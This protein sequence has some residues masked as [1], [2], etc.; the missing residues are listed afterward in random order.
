M[1]ISASFRWIWPRQLRTQ[2]DI[3]KKFQWK[4]NYENYII[5]RPFELSG[6]GKGR[7]GSIYPRYVVWDGIKVSQKFSPEK[8]TRKCK[9][10]APYRSLFELNKI[11]V[12]LYIPSIQFLLVVFESIFS[13]A[14]GAMSIASLSFQ[15]KLTKSWRGLWL[16]FFVAWHF[17]IEYRIL[18]AGLNFLDERHPGPLPATCLC[19]LRDPQ[20]AALSMCWKLC[21]ATCCLWNRLNWLIGAILSIPA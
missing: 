14:L 8:K 18:P 21:H 6:K 16:I 17:F 4:V 13:G 11:F 9:R 20:N 10:F 7:G 1:F 12:F 15:K 19:G 2:T 3:Y 5:F